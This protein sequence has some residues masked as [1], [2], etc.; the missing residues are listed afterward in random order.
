M[1]Q[2]SNIF[3]KYQFFGNMRHGIHSF[4]CHDIFIVTLYGVRHLFRREKLL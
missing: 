1:I 3:F 2:M 4:C